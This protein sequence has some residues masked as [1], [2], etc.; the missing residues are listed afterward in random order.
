MAHTTKTS[1]EA[2]TRIAAQYKAIKY[3]LIRIYAEESEKHPLSFKKLRDQLAKDGGFDVSY[4]ALRDVLTDNEKIPNLCIVIGLCRLWNLDYADVL[5]PPEEATQPVPSSDALT[6]RSRILDDP[7]YLGVFHGCIR[8]RNLD[9]DEIMPFELEIKPYG[10][11][12]SATMTTHS[13]PSKVSGEVKPYSET[14]TGTPILLTKTQNVFILLTSEKGHFYFL[15]FKYRPYNFEKLYFRRGI[16][17]S[18]ETATNNLILQNFVLFLQS[19]N[20]DKTPYISGLLKITDEYLWVPKAEIDTMLADEEF[21]NLLHKYGGTFIGKAP[22][23]IYRIKATQI[24]DFIE[25]KKDQDEVDEAMRVLYAIQ[26]KSIAPDG[27]KYY[28]LDGL[29]GF[30]KNYLQRK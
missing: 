9:R 10:S 13:N 25:D 21:A 11:G 3:R 26:G 8:T 18:T 19:V 20:K 17:V 4:T 28:N 12:V 6:A 22:R 24:L 5:A 15:F 1:R 23:E 27:I 14:F 30:A 7:N 2:D 29:P 16:A